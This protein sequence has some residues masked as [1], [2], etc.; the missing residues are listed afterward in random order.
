MPLVSERFRFISALFSSKSL[1]G[2]WTMTLHQNGHSGGVRRK[3]GGGEKQKPCLNRRTRYRGARGVGG[4]KGWET[5]KG[6]LHAL[7][8]ALGGLLCLGVAG[9]QVLV[10]RLH[11]QRCC[12]V[13]G[14]VPVTLP[15]PRVTLGLP[16]C[17]CTGPGTS[18]GTRH[19][20]VV[21]HTGLAI[22]FIVRKTVV[23]AR[24]THTA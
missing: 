1:S 15:L 19:V 7:A 17:L 3:E 12:K 9:H 5:E 24:L 13:Q 20:V 4:W 21:V 16:L 18:P 22:V 10:T 14:N 11:V 23:H 8:L 2:W 6:Q